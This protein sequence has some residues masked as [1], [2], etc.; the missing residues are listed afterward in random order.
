MYFKNKKFLKIFFLVFFICFPKNISAQNIQNIYIPCE[1][2]KCKPEWGPTNTRWYKGD[3][4]KKK[5]AIIWYGG[6]KGNYTSADNQ[7]INQLLG[8]FDIIV[9]ASPFELFSDHRTQGMPQYVNDENLIFIMFR[10]M[11]H[12]K[13]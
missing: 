10:C 12:S 9:V 7:P 8:K 2:E 5:P 13:N 6:G 3:G 4:D 1:I 11:S